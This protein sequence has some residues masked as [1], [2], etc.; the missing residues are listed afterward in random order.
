VIS[1]VSCQCSSIWRGLLR[2]CIIACITDSRRQLTAEVPDLII[3][4]RS[5]HAG[6]PCSDRFDMDKDL[7]FYPYSP[8]ETAVVVGWGS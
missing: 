3:V 8:E 7:P 2:V 1:L 5:S 6:S 4:P